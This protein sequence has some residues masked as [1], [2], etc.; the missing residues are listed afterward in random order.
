V[1]G[2]LLAEGSV[3]RGKLARES[4]LPENHGRGNSI[5]SFTLMNNGEV[6]SSPLYIVPAG[7]T[8]IVTDIVVFSKDPYNSVVLYLGRFYRSVSEV[9]PRAAL[10]VQSLE[11]PRVVPLSAIS[12]QAGIRFDSGETIGAQ[13]APN[14]N[15]HV[16]VS[17]YEF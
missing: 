10:P 4:V 3:V 1:D 13:F 8:F 11:G 5:R 14:V 6:V 9:E 15:G 2:S 16:T 12:F 7:K 17:G